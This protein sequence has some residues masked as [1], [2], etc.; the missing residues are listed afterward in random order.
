MIDKTVLKKHKQGKDLSSHYEKALNLSRFFILSSFPK[1][2]LKVLTFC[3]LGGK[4]SMQMWW[5]LDSTLTARS[6][7]QN[8]PK[9]QRFIS[10][11]K[12]KDL[13]QK[14]PILIKN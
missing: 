11:E 14:C 7:T 6:L 13:F 12:F 4:F 10:I 2:P 9:V 3:P 8:N 1:L 5:Y